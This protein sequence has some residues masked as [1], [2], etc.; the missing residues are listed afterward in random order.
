MRTKQ[1]LEKKQAKEKIIGD[2]TQKN[3]IPKL[4]IVAKTTSMK[5]HLDRKTKRLQPDSQ[6]V[7]TDTNE[8]K[9]KMKCAKLDRHLSHSR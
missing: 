7:Q 5:Q 4:S 8:L 6:A 9:M 3:P 1:K 2:W